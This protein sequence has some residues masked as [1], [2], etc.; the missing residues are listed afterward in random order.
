[1]PLHFTES[2]PAAAPTLVFLH[3]GGI[4]AWMWRKHVA[5]FEQDYHCLAPDLPE[6]GQSTDAGEFSMARAV[7]AVAELI[8]TRAH[9]GRAH[10]VGLSL[11]A[12]VGAGVLAVAARL[13][14]RSLLTGTLTQPMLGAGLIQ[15]MMQWYAPVKD[16]EFMIRANFRQLGLPEE[17][18]ADFAA[19]TRRMSAAALGRILAANLNFRVPPGLTRLKTPVLV[20]VGEKEPRAMRRSARELSGAMLGGQSLMVAGHGHNWPLTAPEL[21]QRVLRAWLRDEPLPGELAAVPRK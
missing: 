11:G 4:G 13:A 18:Y 3:G 10:L 2:G 20:L 14:D 8:H 1:M 16:W 6:Q 21:F 7:Q 15:P 9:D 12:Q 19:D 5:A 17:Y